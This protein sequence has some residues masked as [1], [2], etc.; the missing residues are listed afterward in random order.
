VSTTLSATF[1][2][3]NVV[4]IAL[5]SMILKNEEKSWWKLLGVLIAVL[6]AIGTIVAPML[7]S[8]GDSTAFDSRTLIGVGL[9]S[10][11]SLNSAVN[12]NLQTVLMTRYN[13]PP[14]MVTAWMNFGNMFFTL[15]LV[16]FFWSQCNFAGADWSAYY[17]VFYAGV[18]GA[19]IPWTINNFV[20]KKLKPIAVTIYAC[21][22]TIFVAI[23]SYLVLDDTI[24]WY[25]A[26]G[27]LV[28]ISGVLVVAYA[29]YRESLTKQVKE[30]PIVD[31]EAPTIVSGP[32]SPVEEIELDEKLEKL[33][34]EKLLA[35]Q[36]L[37][38]P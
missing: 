10:I 4:M 5:L 23:F 28:I 30:E 27:A 1:T 7:F 25:T 15:A 32:N 20:T 2:P 26:V 14:L 19:S 38:E 6:G 29:K 8:F 21:T 34:A 17:G 37:E 11:N 36:Q 31:V 35:V 16:P 18:I 13:M 3:V 12:V 33:D 24:K 22:Q 9:L